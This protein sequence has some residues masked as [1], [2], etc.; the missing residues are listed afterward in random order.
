VRRFHSN[1]QEE[2]MFTKCLYSLVI[3]LAASAASAQ[4]NIAT[5]ATVYLRGEPGSWVSGAV[6]APEATWIHGVQGLFFG[7]TNFDQGATITYNDGNFWSFEFAAPTY[8]PI[9]NTNT[10]Q[11]LQVGFYANATR[12]PFNSPTVPGLNVSGNGRGNNQLSGWFNVLEVSY[13][14]S[15]SISAL[16]VD[17]RQYDEDLTQSGPSLYGSLRFNSG[18]PLTLTPIPEPGTAALFSV[19]LAIAIGRRYIRRENSAA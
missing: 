8:N 13:G 5:T 11:P 9:T 16:A 17:F 14:A 7:A 3:V 2:T 15:G 18:I 1:L 12:F 19:G 10:G 4:S 6:G